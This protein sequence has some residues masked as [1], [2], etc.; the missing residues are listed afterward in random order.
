MVE[1]KHAEGWVWVIVND[2]SDSGHYLGLHSEENDVD[3]IPAFISREA[4]DD[5]YLNLPR[6]K[7]HKYEIQAVHIDELA[8]DAKKNGFT[9]AFVDKDGKIVDHRGETI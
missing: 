3:F 6:Q 9:V 7:G 1:N 2:Q 8:A 5:C 4:A